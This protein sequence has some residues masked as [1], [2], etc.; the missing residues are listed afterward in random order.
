MS[1]GIFVKSDFTGIFKVLIFVKLY[2]DLPRPH[3]ILNAIFLRKKKTHSI[4][5][6]P[7]VLMQ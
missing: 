4:V 3:E 7:E 5:F 6:L 2:I 1:V